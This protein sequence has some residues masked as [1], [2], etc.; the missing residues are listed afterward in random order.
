MV[1]SDSVRT[2]SEDLSL[3]PMAPT[4]FELQVH[5]YTHEDF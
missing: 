1:I 2:C 4:G 3:M 5:L